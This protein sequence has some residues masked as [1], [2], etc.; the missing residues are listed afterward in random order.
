VAAARSVGPGV[1]VGGG[2]GSGVGDR[3]G[4]G[5]GEGTGVALGDKL[6]VGAGVAIAVGD[7]A[8]VGAGAFEA[9]PASGPGA[10]DEVIETQET[11]TPMDRLRNRAGRP[12][13][14]ATR[15]RHGITA[16]TVHPVI[17]P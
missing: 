6:G 4:E 17:G 16:L 5:V 15:G 2:V 1:P 7:R 10:A 8:A 14:R 3:L 9:L 13:P 12:A 11:T